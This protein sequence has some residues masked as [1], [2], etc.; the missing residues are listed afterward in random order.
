MFEFSYRS[1]EVF[2]SHIKYLVRVLSPSIL[3][4]IFITVLRLPTL[5]LNLKQPLFLA[6]IELWPLLYFC[7]ETTNGLCLALDI[8]RWWTSYNRRSSLSHKKHILLSIQWNLTLRNVLFHFYICHDFCWSYTVYK[9]PAYW[10]WIV[11][12]GIMVNECEPV[13]LHAHVDISSQKVPLNPATKALCFLWCFPL[14]G[15]PLWKHWNGF[16][17]CE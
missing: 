9:E 16:Y 14:W 17:K 7:I 3:S 4:I 12:N 5:M 11:L 1:T 8:H 6:L 10:I 13:L 15:G 2:T